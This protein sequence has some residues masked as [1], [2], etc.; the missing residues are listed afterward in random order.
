MYHCPDCSTELTVLEIPSA[1]GKP[2]L[3]TIDTRYYHCP[4][5]GQHF[6][7]RKR[8]YA[9]HEP[10]G[11]WFHMVSEEKMLLMHQPPEW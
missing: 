9:E 4:G 1:A 3:L 6:L 11:E 8:D 10:T 2:Q 7:Y 5:C